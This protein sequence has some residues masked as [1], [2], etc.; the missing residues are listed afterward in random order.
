MANNALWP[1]GRR[2][3]FTIFDDTDAATLQNVGPVYRLLQDLGFRTT[4]SCWG[5]RGDARQGLFRGETLDDEPYR[6]WLVD[7]EAQGFEIAW[8]GATWHSSDRDR[9]AAGLE[10]FAATFQHDPRVAANHTGCDEAMY[11]GS[12]RLSGWRRML[13]NLLTRYRNRNI[14]KGQI[15]GGAR[16]WGDLC[17]E[18]IKYYRNFVFQDINTLKACPFMP[19]HD[20]ARPWV[21]LWFASSDGHD[22]HATNR[23]IAEANQERLEAEGGACILYTHFAKGFCVDGKIDARFERLITRLADKKGWFV[24][25]SVLLDRLA[26]VNGTCEISDLQRRQIEWK[27]LREKIF[28]GTT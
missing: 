4:K 21:N 26:T 7:L 27:W 24:P 20:P 6:R 16:F 17:R 8:H 3:A 22:V 14:S 28:I 9:T 19:Y 11:W 1:D 23:C 15:E 25:V 12:Y 2:F 5:L 18:K 10:R 13:Y